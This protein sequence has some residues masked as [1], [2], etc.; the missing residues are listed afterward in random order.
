MKDCTRFAP[1]IGARE[2]ELA[3]AEAKALEAH[4]A[5]CPSC[6][7]F[8]RDVAAM[9]GLVGEALLARAAERDFAPFVDAVMAKV[10]PAPRRRGLL[11]WLAGHRRAAAATLAPVLAGLALLVYV[12][13]HAGGGEIA[14]L[15]LTSEGEVTTVLQTADGP[16]VLFGGEGES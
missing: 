9:D 16:V 2:G 6:A 10:D 15:E 4:L 8:A 1:M 13:L 7:A 11:A 3:P 14:I 12:Q 5:Q